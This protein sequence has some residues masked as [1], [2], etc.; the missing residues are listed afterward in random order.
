MLELVDVTLLLTHTLPEWL[1]LANLQVSRKAEYFTLPLQKYPDTIRVFHKYFKDFPF[2][3]VIY[4]RVSEERMKKHG[5]L[6]SLPSR[7][8]IVCLPLSG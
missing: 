7:A 8:K 1:Q 6:C 4:L 3:F 5:F 2:I